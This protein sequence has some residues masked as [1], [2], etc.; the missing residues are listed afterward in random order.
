M[1]GCG[2]DGNEEGLGGDSAVRRLPGR[3]VSTRGV[4]HMA[5]EE[6]GRRTFSPLYGQE[7]SRSLGARLLR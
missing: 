6:D 5:E 1:F 7:C 2:R 3:L 4:F